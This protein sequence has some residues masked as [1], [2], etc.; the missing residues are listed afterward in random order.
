MRGAGRPVL[1][2]AV[3]NLFLRVLFVLVVA[4]VAFCAFVADSTRGVVAFTHGYLF[5]CL[6]SALVL[7]AAWFACFG[8]QAPLVGCLVFGLLAAALVL[9]APSARLLRSAMLK[10]PPDTDAGAIEAVVKQEYAGSAYAIPRM[11][12]KRANISMEPGEPARQL[13]RIH[14]SLSSHD[15]SDSTSIS[16]IIEDGAVL[17][18][19]FAAD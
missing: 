5:F 7:G 8:K 4:V 16:F 14:F 18:G 9:P 1:P 12:R 13:E 6:V 3:M 17:Q 10:L 15:P 11:S 19:S 2:A